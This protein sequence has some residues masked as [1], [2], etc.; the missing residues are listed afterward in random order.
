MKQIISILLVFS[1]LTAGAQSVTSRAV[2]QDL[3]TD[4]STYW[5]IST[6]STLSYVNTTPGAWY[7]T[8]RSGGGMIVHFKFKPNGR[9]IFQLYMQSNSYGSSLEAWTEVEGSVQFTRDA[10]GQDIFVT[11]A[12][13]G[14]YR[15]NRNGVLGSRPIP[16]DE[17][18]GQHSCTYL[19]QKT[20]FADD[21]SHYYL[22]TVD[23]EKYP[24]ADVNK[25]GTIDPAWISKF[26]I[27]KKS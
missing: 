16:E 13:K 8:T 6:L 23:L 27:P 15:T 25:A 17:L 2:P 22:L 9:F 24:D 19:W 7:N 12:E 21:P 4:D 10:K 26:H 14:T 11:R 5:T 20:E 1:V 18:K 3:V